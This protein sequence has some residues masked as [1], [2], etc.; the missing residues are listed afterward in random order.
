[1][2]NVTK[3]P[4]AAWL[5]GMIRE[6]M[7]HRP[8]RMGVVLVMEDGEVLTGYYGDHSPEDIARMAYHL[9]MDSLWQLIGVNADQIVRMA[10]EME[11]QEDSGDEDRQA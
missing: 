9:N 8:V 2:D 10:K 11:E 7:E 3:T 6:I 1:M 5:E 4:Y